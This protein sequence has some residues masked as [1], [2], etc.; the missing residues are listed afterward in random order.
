MTHILEFTEK[1]FKTI[2]NMI[3]DFKENINIMRLTSRQSQL[4]NGNY[5]EDPHGNFRTDK[6]IIENKKYQILNFKQ[7]LSQLK[8]G[9]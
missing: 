6:C 8:R 1:D 7:K 4:K 3:K 2:I 5:K 9:K